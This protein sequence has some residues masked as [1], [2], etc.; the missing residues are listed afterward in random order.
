MTLSRKQLEQYDRQIQL[1]E[2]GPSGQEILLNSKVLVI[3][4][5]G[6]G[7]AAVFYLAVAGIGTMG[8]AD[9]DVVS[10]SN[11]QRQILHTVKDINRLKT[12]SAQEKL[13]ALNP[14][15]IIHTYP[16]KISEN[17]IHNIIQDY[18]IVIDAVDNFETK[19][20]IND[21]CVHA[22]KPFI[23][24]GVQGFKGQILTYTPG[25]TCY[26]CVFASPPDI[27]I[28]KSILG[29]TAGV[30][31]VLQAAEAV[32]YLLN[33][34]TLLT[35]RILEINLLTM[36]FREIPVKKD[37]YCPVCGKAQND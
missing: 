3:G 6:L 24:A 17:T 15:I 32:K 13:S 8:I 37:P 25:H 34:G 1:D 28:D 33:I 14:D 11:L 23:H 2:I 26:R 36:K 21:A 10:L 30:V 7:S 16:E 9:F 18:D 4:A 35:D 22:L 5:G 12:D 29:S 19:F 27:E 31:G 20:L